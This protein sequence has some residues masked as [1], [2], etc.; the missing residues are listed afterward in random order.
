[1]RVQRR[2]PAAKAHGTER[3]PT[4]HVRTH[5]QIAYADSVRLPAAN[6]RPEGQDD[7]ADVCLRRAGLLLDGEL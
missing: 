2:E 6:A 4:I 1:V 5:C 7:P 3:K